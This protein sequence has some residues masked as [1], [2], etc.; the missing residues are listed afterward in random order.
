MKTLKISS[1]FICITLLVACELVQLESPEEPNAN[2]GFPETEEAFITVLTSDNSRE[3]KAIAFFL[4][5]LDGLQSC[6]LDDS[7]TF[8]ND[9]TYRY[10]GGEFLC[11][12]ADNIRIKTGVWEVNFDN[13]EVIFD[14]GTS[15]E[16]TAKL[17]S[18]VENRIWFSG[19]VDIFG[20]MMDIQGAYQLVE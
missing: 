5:G 10:D 3:W 2:R 7:F 18:N 13:L 11:G 9:G 6:R 8:F 4:E 15:I 12:D 14:Q 20:I 17:Q 16:S 19:Q 1:I